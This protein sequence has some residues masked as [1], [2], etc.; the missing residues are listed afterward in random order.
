[1]R[2]PL[3]LQWEETRYERWLIANRILNR[4]ADEAFL[5]IWLIA[6]IAVDV[7][8]FGGFVLGWPLNGISWMWR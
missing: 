5:R 1:M 4:Q 7:V 3:W 8:A 6:W 2:K